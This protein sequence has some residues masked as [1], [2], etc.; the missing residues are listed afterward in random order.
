MANS[1]EG[2]SGDTAAA[3]PTGVHVPEAGFAH[4]RLATRMLGARA[5]VGKASDTERAGA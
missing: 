2:Y 3:A 1:G 5:S 4:C